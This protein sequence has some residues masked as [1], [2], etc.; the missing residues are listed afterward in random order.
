[1]RVLSD[2]FPRGL[3]TAVSLV[4][5]VKMLGFMANATHKASDKGH[6]IKIQHG[7]KPGGSYHQMTNNS[8]LH[9]IVMN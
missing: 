5:K 8:L 9:K 6:S 7:S 1:M 4:K 3:D 2:V